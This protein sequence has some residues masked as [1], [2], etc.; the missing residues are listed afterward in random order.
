[1]RTATSGASSPRSR[2]SWGSSPCDSSRPPRPVTRKR[3]PG[4]MA[5]RLI[6]S[7]T[8]GPPAKPSCTKVSS[9][10]RAPARTRASRANT[11]SGA[12]EQH[13]RL[14]DQVAAQVPQQT[15]AV[16]VGVRLAPALAL[17]L[18]APALPA[19]LQAHQRAD[20][21]RQ[22]A[23][24]QEVAVPAAV[25][26]HGQRHAGLAARPPPAGRRRPR[27]RPA[28][29]RPPPAAP[30]RSDRSARSACARLGAA[31]TTR[32]NRDGSA[33]MASAESSSSA[34]GWSRATASRRPGSEVTTAATSIPS[35][36]AMSGAC[37]PAPAGP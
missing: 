11:L 23:H 10:T 14:V 15:A 20:R 8:S 13:Q 5:T 19:R 24:G 37:S 35:V 33:Q 9:S 25:V 1:M 26:E 36:R 30:S 7:W 32:S 21:R 18:R 4:S 12:P 3:G 28:A 2:S 31:T 17:H 29:C 16:G 22:L 34:P 6:H 27:S